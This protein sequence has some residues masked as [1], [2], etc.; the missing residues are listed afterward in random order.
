LAIRS[1]KA[2][3]VLHH[4][5]RTFP[6]A[7]VAESSVALP[8]LKRSAA[9]PEYRIY[10]VGHDGRFAGVKELECVGDAEA[11][12]EAKQL[13]DGRDIELWQRARFIQRFPKK[14]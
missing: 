11:I 8:P 4:R 1:G 9:V 14:V 5:P 3:A 6:K 2:Q 13:I 10:F 12:E 7:S